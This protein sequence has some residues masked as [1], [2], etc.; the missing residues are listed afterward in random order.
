MTEAQLLA[1]TGL[2]AFG[3]VLP[4]V[5]ALIRAGGF[6]MALGNRA[7]ISALPEWAARASRAQRN[8]V[9]TLVPFLA[10]VIAVQMAGL[11]NENTQFGM[12]LFFWGRVA[13][14][15]IY[16]LGIPYLRTLAF[17]VS[18]S[19]MLRVAREVVPIVSPSTLFADFF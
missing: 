10:I 5:V 19:G 15:I 17:V 2:L 6:R 14:A 16:I 4:P 9:D 12:A 13:H 18:L 11:S 8:M 3:L 1:G 7:E